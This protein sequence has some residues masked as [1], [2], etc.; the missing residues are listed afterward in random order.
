MHGEL[1]THSCEIVSTHGVCCAGV[2]ALKYAAMAVKTGDVRTAV[3]TGTERASSLLHAKHFRAELDAR[4]DD[5]DNPYIAF[6]QEFLRY[7]LSDGSGAALV[8]DQPRGLALRVDWIDIVSFAHELPTCMY[9]GAKRTEDGG[10]RGY[11]DAGTLEDALRE[12]Y[13]NLHQ[14]VKVLGQNIV[15]VSTTKTLEVLKKKRGFT[16]DQIDWVVPHYSSEFFRAKSYDELVR[17]GF[18]IPYSKWCSTL[19]ERGNTGCASVLIMLNDLLESGR[20]EPGHRVVLMVPESG[21]FS[22]AWAMLTAVQA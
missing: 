10:L 19:T 14:D 13:F 9:M 12:G 18:E 15:T 3:A 6:D 7:M 1:G 16:P 5:E 20:V 21:R 4:R 2:T 8:Q 11:R 22:A 17:S